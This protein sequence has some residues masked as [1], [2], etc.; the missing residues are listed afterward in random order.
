[1]DT[2]THALAGTLIAQAGFRQRM[3]PVAT[4]AL[5]VSALAPDVDGIVR[6]QD[7][8]FYL[9][10]HRGIT[11]SFAGG[12][13]MALV[14][15]AI[16]YRFSAYKQYWRLAGLCYFGILSHILLD[17]LTSYGTMI[18][19]PFS[20]R[21][22]SWDTLFIIDVFV[23]GIIVAGIVLAYC[24]SSRSIQVGR[25]ALGLLAGYILIAAMSHHLALTRFRGRVERAGFSPRAVAVFPM[26]FGPLRWSGVVATEEATYQTIYSLLDGS[27]RSFKV[28]PSPP[29]SALIRRAE[30]EDV[31]ILFRSF[32]RFPVVRVRQE[33]RGPVVQYFDLQFNQIEG[34]LPFLLEVVF[35]E[36]GEPVFAGFA[37]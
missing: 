8:A 25:A 19:L 29:Q 5:T 30:G 13:A 10:Y 31:V 15:A 14:L 6:F 28:Y 3:G 35:D 34:R 33:G 37:R 9:E 16:F 17:L 23:S 7:I 11:H 36:D 22:Y 4:A 20:D 27:D 24:W 26:P 32:A 21:R 2:V 1:M 12:A 18:F